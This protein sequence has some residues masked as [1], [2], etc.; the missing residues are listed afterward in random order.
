MIVGGI[1][2]SACARPSYQRLYASQLLGRTG[3]ASGQRCSRVFATTVRHRKDEAKARTVQH[4]VAQKTEVAEGVKP[5]SVQ[6][7]KPAAPSKQTSL[8]SEQTVSNKEQRKAD[9]AI[10]KDMARYLWPK[11]DFGTRFRVGLSVGLL[12]G[13]KVAFPSFVLHTGHRVDRLIG[14][15][16]TSSILLQRHCRLHEHRFCDSRRYRDDRCGCFYICL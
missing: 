5:E 1:V 11:N 15:Q 6:K 4:E 13:A 8:L 16:C 12:V 7:E 2:R 14:S 9:W 3:Y 10:I